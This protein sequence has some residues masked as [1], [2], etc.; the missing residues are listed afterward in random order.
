MIELLVTA[1]IL[2][3]IAAVGG[4]NL[5]GYYIRQNLKLTVEEVTA[6]IRDAQNRTL[7]AQDGNA[8]DQGDQ[9]GVHFENKTSAPDLVELFCC[10]QSYALGTVVSA[11]NLR[12]GVELN[13]PIE[14]NSKDIVLSKLTG[15]PNAPASIEIAL[16]NNPANS[17][18]ITISEIGQVLRSP[19]E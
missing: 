1:A 9:W 4:I 15:Y 3:A 2:A 6:L 13:D 14:G 18:V 16:K 8:D 17:F 7:V 19:L 5:F 12:I 10:G 11:Y